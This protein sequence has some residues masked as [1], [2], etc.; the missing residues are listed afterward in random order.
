MFRVPWLH[1]P[2]ASW[3]V[4]QR[5]QQAPLYD[6]AGRQ[7][8]VKRGK[9]GE[10]FHAGQQRLGGGHGHRPCSGT[11][12]SQEALG[13]ALGAQTVTVRVTLGECSFQA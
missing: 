8:V 2:T 6:E 10:L 7:P 3:Q 5:A 12:S 11:G 4:S 13:R 9:K 1:P